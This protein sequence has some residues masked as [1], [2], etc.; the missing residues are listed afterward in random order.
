MSGTHLITLY[1]IIVSIDV[2]WSIATNH[3]AIGHVAN[4]HVAIDSGQMKRDQMGQ[5]KHKY[6]KAS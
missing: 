2:A 1:L 6:R 5:S 4:V 3:V